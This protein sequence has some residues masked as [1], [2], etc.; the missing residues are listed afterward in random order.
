VRL[1][2]LIV[3]TVATAGWLAA[4]VLAPALVQ[5]SGRTATA[6][7]LSYLAGGAICHQQPVRSFH[8]AG[9]PMPICARCAGL[10]AGGLLGLA[11]GLAWP[12][13]ARPA[14]ERRRRALVATIAVAAIPTALSVAA[15]WSG[16]AAP[17]NLLRSG[18]ALPLGASVAL[19]VAG[20][21]RGDVA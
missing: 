18:L 17:G 4:T 1:A 15:E 8:V 21:V 6:A 12:T 10:Y 2:V 16:L 13:A 9:V 14:P 19:L 5:G 20:A 11:L 3:A 7:A